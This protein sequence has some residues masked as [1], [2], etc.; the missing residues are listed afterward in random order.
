MKSVLGSAVAALFTMNPSAAAP[1]TLHKGILT[2]QTGDYTVDFR[3]QNAWTIRSVSYK[4][5]PLI[6]PTGGN[7]A[8]LR[9]PDP[10]RK[11][12]LFIGNVHGGEQIESFTLIADG[13][14]YPVTEG[15]AAPEAEEYLLVKAS[16]MGPIRYDSKVKISSQGVEESAS[17]QVE[18]DPAG[19]EWIYAFMHCWAPEMS[20]W[21]AV[22]AD[23][24]PEEGTFRFDGSNTLK[25]DIQ[26]LTVWSET[27]GVG[28]V[29]TYDQPYEGK[30][31][32]HNFIWNR[33][34]DSKHYF[35]VSMDQALART[36]PYICRIVGFQAS[37][38]DWK[39]VALKSGK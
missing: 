2:V 14:S 37:P 31:K 39:E 11:D 19:V 25:K 21:I 17:F 1:P 23:Q 26:S 24:Q 6:V 34:S 18:S 38:H 12:P 3:Q 22:L 33:Q 4:G 13:Q 28:A 9:L 30:P 29:M 15:M 8:V 20:Q 35:Q 16:L 27:T 36:S 7:Q 5:T 32:L 10:E